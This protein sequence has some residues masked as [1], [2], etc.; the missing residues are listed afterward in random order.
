MS[1]TPLISIIMPAYNCE[2]TVIASIESALNQT[3]ENTQLIIT[4]DCSTDRTL[5]ILE[6]KSASDVRIKVI[7]N[8]KNS[9][10]ATSR[11]NAIDVAGGE[12]LA[13]LDS[14]D[15]WEPTK[16]EKQL[17]LMSETNCDICYASYDYFDSDGKQVYD[18]Y[19]VPETISYDG[20]LKEN[21]IGLSTSVLRRNTLGDLRFNTLM[22]HED[23]AL[24]LIL[25][26][27]GANACGITEVL[28]H[29]R[30]GGRSE[31]KWRSMGNRWKI[32]RK[33]E[34]L[35]IPKSF[36]YLSNYALAGLKKYR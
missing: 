34:K 15:L 8:D 31:N 28:S 10:V 27:S 1:L 3:Y 22:F 9:G 20:L 30:I 21:V 2:N 24:W 33:A 12:F 26:R 17:K 5:D 18:T 25:L 16:L 6:N 32:Y 36:W 29:N 11:N 35:S 19:T 4:N 7:T 13:F 23:F 14:D